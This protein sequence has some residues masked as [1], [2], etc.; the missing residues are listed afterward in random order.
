L[1][2]LADAEPDVGARPR[3]ELGALVP[4]NRLKSSLVDGRVAGE[5]ESDCLD[6]LCAEDGRFE[7]FA[8]TFEE[9]EDD[10]DSDVWGVLPLR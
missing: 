5:A 2:V 1:L 7:L 8:P 3:A 6:L 9:A 4:I 10:D